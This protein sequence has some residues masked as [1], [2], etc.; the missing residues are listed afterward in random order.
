MKPPAAWGAI[1]PA[2]LPRGAE[3]LRQ[4]TRWGPNSRKMAS[5]PVAYFAHAGCFESKKTTATPRL[6]S[7]A[8]AR[9]DFQSIPGQLQ[10][11]SLVLGSQ[12]PAGPRHYVALPLTLCP[13]K[14][15]ALTHR[16][17][18]MSLHRCGLALQG[19]LS[20]AG[21]GQFEPSWLPGGHFACVVSCLVLPTAKKQNIEAE[22]FRVCVHAEM[23]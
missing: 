7:A 16:T 19:P 9:C 3:G 23:H 6:T 12:P 22:G 21:R 15:R 5:H 13:A 20:L 10:T 11:W 2:A 17:A 8:Q 4:G 1:W 18:E 14:R